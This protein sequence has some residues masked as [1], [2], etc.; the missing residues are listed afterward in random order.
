[1]TQS[2]ELRIWLTAPES[3]RAG[4]TF[5]IAIIVKNVGEAVLDLY[6]RGR[7]IAYDILVKDATGQVVW[8]R[9]QDEIIPGVIQLR[10]LAPGEVLELSHEWNQRTRAG[11]LVEPGQYMVEGLVLTDGPIPLAPVPRRFEIVPD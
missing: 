2:A 5:S 11:N 1:M 8:R 6:L 7:D 10:A 4:S 9:L 3:A